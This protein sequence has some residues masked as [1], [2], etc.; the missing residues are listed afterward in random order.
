MTHMTSMTYIIARLKFLLFYL[1]TWVG[2][3]QLARLI[4][5]LS[6][7]NE[8]AKLKA[9]NIFGSFLYGLR[10]DLS[11]AAYLTIPVCVFVLLAAFIPLF[12]KAIIYRIY[13]AVLIFII[14]LILVADIEIFNQ[15]GFRIDASPL[16]YL[17]SPKEVWASISHLPILL[18]LSLFV[19]FFLLINYGVG[20]VIRRISLLLQAGVPVIPALLIPVLF[21]GLLIIPVRGGF[22]LTPMN[23]SIVYFST[24]NFANQAAV[25]APWNLM[26][27]LVSETGARKNP[28]EYMPGAEAA[29]IKDSLY[30]SGNRSMMLLNNPKP[31]IILIIWESF[32]AKA[33]TLTIDG[34]EVTPHFNRLKNEG[35]WFSNAYASGDRTDK[36]IAAVLSGYPAL[37]KTSVIRLPSKVTKLETI[38]GIYKKQGYQTSFYYGGETEFA[39]IKSFI[40]HNGFEKIMDKSN[41]SSKDLNSKWGAH[42]GVV[43]KKIVSDLANQQEPFLTTWLTL[44]SHE[45]FE[46]PVPEVFHG[47]D[48]TTKFLNSLHYTDAVVFDF[49]GSFKK[50]P[51]WKNTIVVIVADHGHPLPETGSKLD[52]FKIPILFL[53]GALK[54]QGLTID[55]LCSQLDIAA[56]LTHQ[57]SSPGSFPFSKNILDSSVSKWAFFTFNDGF[58]FVQPGSP[59]LFDNVGKILLPGYANDSASVKAGKAMQ[60][61]TYQDYVDK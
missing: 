20:K 29:K 53:G 51:S 55:A 24:N 28:Y 1:L 31:N 40:I 19:V 14:L 11:M 49:I 36:G 41:F 57:T 46:T 34:K 15:W 12:R 2:F 9:G 50:L 42:D 6:H 38:P 8:T 23:Q 45:P 21:A 39:N 37:P 52:N 44:S 33:T 32:T 60:Q 4:F 59:V 7:F 27:T 61:V 25:N 35:I 17:S 5:L 16:K 18:Y 54:Q 30:R 13:T 47:K 56:T 26:Y 48:H 10:M 43:A 3:F 58:G 22:Q